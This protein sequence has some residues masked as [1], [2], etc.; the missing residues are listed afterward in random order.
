MGMRA[1]T[2]FK[3]LAKPVSEQVAELLTTNAERLTRRT[4]LKRT[5]Y[6]V[7]G[8]PVSEVCRIYAGTMY[9][10]HGRILTENALR[11]VATAIA[12]D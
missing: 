6:T 4:Q 2:S 10:T 5:P 11:T 12:I 7:L 9:S 3:S 1:V 8:Q